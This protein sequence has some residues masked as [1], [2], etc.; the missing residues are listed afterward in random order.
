MALKCLNLLISN[1]L[2]YLTMVE[3][4][5]RS[6]AISLGSVFAVT[7]VLGGF[8]FKTAIITIFIII[9]IVLNLVTATTMIS[10]T[11]TIIF[12]LT[13]RL[14]LSQFFL[15]YIFTHLLG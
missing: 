13:E 8:D 12:L 7:L 14:H 10:T 5:V 3:D 1:C 9:L 11:K 15:H 4:T 6:L 2:Q